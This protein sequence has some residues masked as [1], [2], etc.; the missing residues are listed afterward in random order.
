MDWYSWL[1]RTTL[2]PSL[3]YEYGFMFTRNELE[4]DDVAYFDHEFLKSM[5]ISI[6]KHR[7]EILKLAMKAK[8]KSRGGVGG[9]SM[10]TTTQHM[11]KL[12]TTALK[13]TKSCI[14]KYMHT[15]VHPNRHDSSSIVIV[16]GDRRRG[17]EGVLKRDRKM[18][19][20]QQGRLMFTNGGVKVSSNCPSPLSRSAT[21]PMVSSC[22]CKSGEG[23]DDDDNDDDD[24]YRGSNDGNTFKWDSMFKDLK[25]T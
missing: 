2:E 1:S 17:T 5:G 21:S 3:V 8:K 25:P 13:R 19:V 4:G 23:D 24:G 16:R 15:L 12:L 7:L 18:V 9:G 22:H 6:A 11:H 14:S 20:V 10:T